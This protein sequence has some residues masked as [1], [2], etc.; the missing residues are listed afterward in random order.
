MEVELD[1]RTILDT[2]G[3]RPH[4]TPS[5]LNSILNLLLLKMLEIST[6]LYLTSHRT[7]HSEITVILNL[8]LLQ[9]LSIETNVRTSIKSGDTACPRYRI[10]CRRPF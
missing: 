3:P 7:I 1:F 10:K 2:R 9:M 8:L 5:T 4:S 6:Y